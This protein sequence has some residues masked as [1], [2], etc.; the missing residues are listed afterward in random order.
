MDSLTFIGTATT[1]LRLG[2]FTLLTDPNFIRRG[3]RAYLGRGLWTRRLIDPAMRPDELPVLDAIVLSHLHGDH[4]D[5][6]AR[7]ELDR[8]QPVLTT[9]HAAPRLRRQGFPTVG[10]DTWEDRVLDRPGEQLRVVSLPGIHARGPLGKVLPPVMGSL[11]EHSVDGALRRRVY[12]SGD[13]LTGDHLD[14]IRERFEDIDVA[15]VHLGGTRILAHRVTMDATEGVDF[16]RRIRPTVAVPI[17]Y[18]DYKVF[19]SGLSEFLG[20]AAD[21]GLDQHV[22]PVG[23][24]ETFALPVV[25]SPPVS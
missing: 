4:W 9:T 15:V 2:G 5:R 23:R 10:L 24:G 22:R 13:T 17:H 16:L 11:L 1:V 25:E 21:A 14:A 20:L 6:V 7:R 18:D 12:I 8:G 19:R 3:Q